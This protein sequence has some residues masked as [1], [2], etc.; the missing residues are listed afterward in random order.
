V[1]D[2]IQSKWKEERERNELT[3]MTEAFYGAMRDFLKQRTIKAKEEI[4]PFIKRMLLSRLDRLQYVIN[5]LIKIRTTK[6]IRM[7]TSKEEITIS[8]TREESD[9]YTRMK[10][11]YD[12]YKKEIFSPKD[13][14]FTDIEAIL[15]SED[16]EKDEDI[17][18]VAVRFLKSTKDK[19]QGL[20]GRTYGPFAKEDVCLLPKENAIGFVRREI[21][22][23]I[24]IK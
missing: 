14:A 5:D 4:N 1:F 12:I 3:S 15:D 8:I 13:V 22:E 17:E 10:K 24:D 7:V 6:I 16:T 9:F 19:I 2:K 23:D 11:I 21:A 20:D 18:Y